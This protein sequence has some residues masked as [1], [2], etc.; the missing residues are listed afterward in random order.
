[1]RIFQ[2]CGITYNLKPECPLEPEDLRKLSALAKTE[3]QIE[4]TRAA[5]SATSV[6]TELKRMV[7]ALQR[8]EAK[9]KRLRGELKEVLA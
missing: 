3:K 9:I 1:M 4:E 5:F 2:A 8:D 7:Q 6:N